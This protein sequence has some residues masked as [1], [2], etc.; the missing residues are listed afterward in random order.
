MVQRF[1]QV[2]SI[3]HRSFEHNISVPIHSQKF[4]GQS[5]FWRRLAHFRVTWLD[6]KNFFS[7][8]RT[9]DDEHQTSL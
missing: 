9:R 8:Q 5:Q 7:N 2:A 1:F 6:W 4:V 3:N